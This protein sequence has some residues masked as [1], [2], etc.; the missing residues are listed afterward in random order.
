ALGA[1]ANA[2]D[3]VL[4]LTTKLGVEKTV[5]VASVDVVDKDQAHGSARM[6]R[7]IPERLH[8]TE[9]KFLT[10]SPSP[11]RACHPGMLIAIPWQSIKE[12]GGEKGRN[13]VT[14]KDGAKFTGTILTEVTSTDGLKYPLASCSK[15]TVKKVTMIETKDDFRPAAK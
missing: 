8:A 2:D 9:K 5:T 6:T 15:M 3:L 12:I 7:R 10:L 1:N 11:S 14:C 4:D 13:T